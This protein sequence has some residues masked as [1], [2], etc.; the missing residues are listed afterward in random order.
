MFFFADLHNDVITELS[1]RKFKRYIKRAH[2]NGVRTMLISVWTTK[3]Q[4]PLQHVKYY[5]QVIDKIS[6]QTKLHLHIEDAWFLNQQ[7]VGEFIALNPY[8]VG[9]TWAEDDRV[10]LEIVERLVKSGIIIDLAHLSERSF[11][12]VVSVIKEEG[13]KRGKKIPLLCTHT[14]FD[15]VN[16]H[17]RNLD[18]E[19]VQKIVDSGG[20]IGLTLVGDFLNK[21]DFATMHDVYVHI[22]YFL[23]NFGTDG[24][25]IGTDFFGTSN[26][27]KGLKNYEHF[28]KLEK[29][30]LSKGLSKTTIDKIFHIN[31]CDF[32]RTME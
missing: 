31:Y 12:K 28:K 7:N 5:R 9:M 1:P 10:D 30:L 32:S 6:T 18:R 26:L 2:R 13:E 3:M 16:P 15:E 11:W 23:D 21:M 8:S 20:L 17:W 14:C 29:F 19:Q 25:G 27:P 22:K 24:L 4:E